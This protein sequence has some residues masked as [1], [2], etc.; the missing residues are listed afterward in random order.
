MG[1]FMRFKE[2][3]CLH[4]IKVYGEAASAITEAAASYPED[5]AEISNEGG[6]STSEQQIFN[7]DE[8][9]LFGK[10]MSSRTSIAKEKSITG[11]KEQ[12]D[13]SYGL[14]QLVTLS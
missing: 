7:V 13:S 1:W 12:A 14:V 10:K 4:N 3:R 2:R 5:P 9:V 8:T 6:Y 11:F